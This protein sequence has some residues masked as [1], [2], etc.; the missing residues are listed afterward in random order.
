MGVPDQLSIHRL[1]IDWHD[2]HPA[3]SGRSES[4]RHQRRR[5]NCR[6]PDDDRAYMLYHPPHDTTYKPRMV[7]SE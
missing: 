5:R 2:E 3:M 6:L 1:A 4:Q 7:N